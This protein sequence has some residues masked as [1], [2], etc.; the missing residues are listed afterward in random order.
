ML[1]ELFTNN[2]LLSEALLNIEDKKI[3]PGIDGVRVEEFDNFL[4][5]NWDNIVDDI[6][7]GKYLPKLVIEEEIFSKKVGRERFINI[8]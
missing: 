4:K 8:V 3:S 7:A 2:D 1:R 6:V 5:L